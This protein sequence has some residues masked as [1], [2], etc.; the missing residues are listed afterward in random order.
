M[1]GVR[2][3]LS[4]RS[5]AQSGG[6]R[7]LLLSQDSRDEHTSRP[8]TP[9]PREQTG[10]ISHPNMPS[11]TTS[12]VQ[13]PPSLTPGLPVPA[14]T[15]PYLST[16]SPPVSASY[17]GGPTTSPFPMTRAT[18]AGSAQVSRQTRPSAMDSTPAV[19][20]G[21]APKSLPTSISP[22]A[23]HSA[24]DEAARATH[25]IPGPAD[26][27]NRAAGHAQ[28]DVHP[29]SRQVKHKTSSTLHKAAEIAHHAVDGAAV[30][31]SALGHHQSMNIAGTGQ[32]PQHQQR[33]NAIPPQTRIARSNATGQLPVTAGRHN[34]A[35]R[36]ASS[37]EGNAWNAGR[38]PHPVQPAATSSGSFSSRGPYNTAAIPRQRPNQAIQHA[39]QP[40]PQ[41]QPRHRANPAASPQQMPAQRGTH[42]AQ[43]QPA[44]SSRPMPHPS[45]S[46]APQMP[47][48]VPPSTHGQPVQTSTPSPPPSQSQ[49]PREPKQVPSSIRRQGSKA[50]DKVHSRTRL[51]AFKRRD[52]DHRHMQNDNQLGA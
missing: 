14:A 16:S 12:S 5:A 22:S 13:H 1:T 35:G 38:Q 6:L 11:A 36:P 17:G 37:D 51:S 43:G 39:S 33:P 44:Q 48:H 2:R 20:P 27:A 29:H 40:P 3:T 32:V 50:R 4:Q 34:Q 8:G 26:H 21:S 47:R 31:A 23:P 24:S 49:V 46:H 28:A 9:S 41:M 45:Q 10:A 52:K 25:H 42:P 30:A 18:Q 19:R 15:S 7:P